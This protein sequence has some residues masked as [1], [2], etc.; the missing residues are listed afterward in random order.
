M[1][2]FCSCRASSDMKLT[3]FLE[4]NKEP[5]RLK[6][7]LHACSKTPTK[8]CDNIHDCIG[9]VAVRVNTHNRQFSGKIIQIYP[10]IKIP[11]P[12]S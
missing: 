5:V 6:D 2:I 9:Q 11:S 1:A 12:V 7:A 8:S 3:Q 10:E 4:D